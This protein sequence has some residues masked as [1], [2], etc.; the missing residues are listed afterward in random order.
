MSTAIVWVAIVIAAIALIAFA[1]ICLGIVRDDRVAGLGLPAGGL[2]SWLARR[3]TGL[4]VELPS[5]TGRQDDT[6]QRTGVS[7]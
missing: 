1:L 4:R 2:G 7:A 5:D 6:Q 3:V